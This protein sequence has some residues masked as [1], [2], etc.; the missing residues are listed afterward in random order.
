MHHR[1]LRPASALSF[2]SILQVAAGRA[3]ARNASSVASAPPAPPTSHDKPSK[4]GTYPASKR[5]NTRADIP[6]A[7]SPRTH[8]SSFRVS[9][10]SAKVQPPVLK[11][12]SSRRQSPKPIVYFHP[13][14]VRDS[15]LSPPDSTCPESP[16]PSVPH[17]SW[18]DA[19]IVGT[20]V[21]SHEIR[22]SPLPLFPIAKTAP[23]L[24]Q[25]L[26]HLLSYHHPRPTFSA[27]LDYHDLHRDLRSTRSYNL[28]ISL[29]LRTGSYGAVP[30]LLSSMHME[31]IPSNIETWTLRTRWLVQSGWWDKAWKEAIEAFP[32]SNIRETNGPAKS[33]F[34]VTDT[35]PLPIWLE[36]FRTVK[37]GMKRQRT[38]I[39]PASPSSVE[40]TSDSEQPSIPDLYWKRYQILMN[41]RPANIPHD[42][43]QTSPTVVYSVVSILLHA[44]EV[45]KAISLTKSYLTNLPPRMSTSRTMKCLDII[46]LHIALGSSHSGL[47]NLFE[48]RRTMI[49]LLASHPALQPTSTT[50]FLLLRQLRRAKHCGTVAQRVVHEFKRKWGAHIEDRRVKR[51]VATL[52]LKEGRMDIVRSIL[53]SERGPRWACATWK[54]MEEVVGKTATP[55]PRRLLRA[56]A[57]KIFKHNGREEAHWRRLLKRVS[58]RRHN[59]RK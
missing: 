7:L 59:R 38:R 54:L 44:R 3:W 37:H 41:N 21:S 42:L 46:H 15:D 36:F 35:L 30:W 52:A 56:P 10:E 45:D 32:R 24:Y 25:N 8:E 6:L 49:S 17:R 9:I 11:P 31:S 26:L 2:S 57:R 33:R 58:L 27:L 19:S 53:H 18:N 34:L 16:G 28:L 23:S 40:S 48:T 12:S 5:H 29:A 13:D 43:A 50:V 51:R 1:A 20:P 39:R 55:R 22:A 14:D 47:R 4:L